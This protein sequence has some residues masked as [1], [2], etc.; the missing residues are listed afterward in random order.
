GDL[1]Y[2]ATKGNFFLIDRMKDMIITGGEYVYSTEVEA[3]IRAM[4]G[5]ADVAVIGVADE[6]WG[7]VVHAAVVPAAGAVLTEGAVIAHCR[8]R[9]AG[10]K[11]PRSVEIRT[12]PLPISG[13]GK[14][15]KN[16]LRAER[17]R[18]LA[19]GR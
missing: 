6:K 8:A 14:I 1:G 19:G 18:I 4:P 9:I 11:A 7:E 16:L 15:A 13:A 3:V 17:E 10:Y 12:A 5:V 2:S